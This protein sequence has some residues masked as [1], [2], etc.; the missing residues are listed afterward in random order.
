MANDNALGPV[1]TVDGPNSEPAIAD[2]IRLYWPI[3]EITHC[4]YRQPFRLGPTH[5][6]MTNQ[7][8]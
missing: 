4:W 1:T 6:F 8:Y 2:P 3:E 5:R 7:V